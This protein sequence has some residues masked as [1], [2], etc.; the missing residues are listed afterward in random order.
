[1]QEKQTS[2]GACL[3]CNKTFAKAG[4]NRH[5]KTHLDEKDNAEGLSYLIKVE[6]NSRWGKTP[7]FLSL[8]IDGE[9]TL[10][11]LDQ[12]L[13]DI[14]LECCGHLSAFRY[15]QAGNPTMN[16]NS[17]MKTLTQLRV[18][19]GEY[20]EIPFKKK[21]KDVFY[22]DLKLDYEYDFGSSTELEI[23]IV[24]VYSCK[25]DQKIVLLSRNEPLEIICAICGKAPAT[26]ICPYCIY[27]E[28]SIFCDKCAKKH[29]KK[30]D[31]FD[32]EC[33]LPVVNSPRVGVCAYDGGTIDVERDVVFVLKEQI[34]S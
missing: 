22:P 7:Y 4:I 9:T 10:K 19:T 29:A 21:A 17:M 25:A 24:A 8:W 31:D 16:L 28:K 30:C 23:S 27:D 5:L 33:S 20:G 13:R 2:Q 3:F 11:Q 12:F 14:W 34:K 1:M 26:Q 18:S 15:K 6:P 32:E